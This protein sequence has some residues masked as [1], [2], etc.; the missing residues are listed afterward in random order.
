MELNKIK[1]CNIY[2]IEEKVFSSQNIKNKTE[3]FRMKD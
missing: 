1:G 3:I 2:F